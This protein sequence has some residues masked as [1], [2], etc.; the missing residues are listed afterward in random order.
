MEGVVLGETL[1]GG[2]A[3]F[4]RRARDERCFGMD[5]VTPG[6]FEN[7]IADFRRRIGSATTRH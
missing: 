7:S 1:R 4:A 5:G 2:L 6:W 3:D